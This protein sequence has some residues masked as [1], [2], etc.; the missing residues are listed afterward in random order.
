M[1]ESRETRRV[2]KLFY[3]QRG[4]YAQLDYHEFHYIILFILR[5]T[6]KNNSMSNFFLCAVLFFYVIAYNHI[7]YFRE[8]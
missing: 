6:T 4:V 1:L 5:S 2:I 3:C 8:K 7:L